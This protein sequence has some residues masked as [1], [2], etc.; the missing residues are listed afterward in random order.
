M[1]LMIDYIELSCSWYAIL[2][3]SLTFGTP[4]LFYDSHHTIYFIVAIYPFPFYYW[5]ISKIPFIFLPFSTSKMV[6]FSIE[7][8]WYLR[9]GIEFKICHGK[10][11]SINDSICYSKN[12]IVI[13]PVVWP[14]GGDA[15]WFS[16]ST[17]YILPYSVG[18]Q[19]LKS[20]IDWLNKQEMN[21]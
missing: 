16:T 19:V 6:S 4:K 18:R 15:T 9:H 5:E 14:V 17:R 21:D 3:Y 8:F 1:I 11:Y 13:G 10:V 20:P 2:Q 12:L 7:K